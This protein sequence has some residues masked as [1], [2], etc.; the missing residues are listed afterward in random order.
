MDASIKELLRGARL[1]LSLTPID[2]DIL[3]KDASDSGSLDGVL[4]A[5]NKLHIMPPAEAL[6]NLLL[7]SLC[8]GK[9]AVAFATCKALNRTLTEE[10]GNILTESTIL[11]GGVEDFLKHPGVTNFTTLT[12]L[13]TT[14]AL[15]VGRTLRLKRKSEPL[16]QR[17][18]L[19]SWVDS[20]HRELSPFGITAHKEIKVYAG[21]PGHFYL[22]SRDTL[23]RLL[24]AL[25]MDGVISKECLKTILTFNF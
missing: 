11:A 3:I 14:I 6:E 1:A 17:I 21:I 20:Y 23:N 19:N 12:M 2:W 7:T 15:G 16:P 24:G 25:L 4:V 9:G 22:F 13:H 10:E 8:S 5:A 18:N